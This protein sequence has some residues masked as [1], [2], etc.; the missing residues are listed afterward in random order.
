MRSLALT[1]AREVGPES[2]V[3][4]FAFVPGIVET[5]VVRET[6]IPGLIEALGLPSEQLE[7]TVLAQNPGYAGLMPVEHCAAGLV[8][9]LVHATEYHGQVADPFE[10]LGRI[11][12]IEIPSPEEAVSVALATEGAIPQHLKQYLTGVTEHNR[13][14]EARIAIRTGSSP[15]R[16]SDRSR[17]FSTCCPS[18]QPIAS[19]GVKRRSQIHSKT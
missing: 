19:N 15:K 2:G 16:T 5:P 11:G 9:A 8:Y 6:L 1:A 3:S 13:E 7:N 10:P 4:I 12:V 17:C 14:L 18:R